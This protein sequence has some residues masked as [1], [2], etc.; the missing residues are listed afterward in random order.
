M[1]PGKKEPPAPEEKRVVTVPKR[2]GESKIRYKTLLAGSDGFPQGLAANTTYVMTEKK[3]GVRATWD[4]RRLLAR[5]GGDLKAPPELVDGLPARRDDIELV[6]E[7]CAQ[8]GDS[9]RLKGLVRSGKER[10]AETH[11]ELQTKLFLFEDLAGKPGRTYRRRLSDLERVVERSGNPRL[12][13]VEMLGE[14]QTPP[15]GS[16]GSAKSKSGIK[17]LGALGA[18]SDWG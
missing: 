15:G 11:E 12:G 5:R 18:F 3:D 9:D 7:L 1:A 14:V 8:R 2:Y 17:A 16:P 13:T 6:G 10:A 4:G